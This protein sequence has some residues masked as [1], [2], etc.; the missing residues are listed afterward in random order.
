[1]TN[2]ELIAKVD[3]A[4]LASVE[5]L[6]AGGYLNPMQTNKFLHGII[7]QPTIIKNCRTVTII[8]EQKKIEK[9]GFG[10]RIMRPGVEHTALPESQYAKPQYGKVELWTKETIAETRI[11]YDTLEANIEKGNLRN[12]IIS[13]LQERIALDLEELVVRGDRDSADPY[14][15]ILDGILKKCNKWIIDVTGEEAPRLGQWTR[16]IR[17]IPAKYL[18]DPNAWRIYTNRLVDLA[19]KNHIASR[20]TVAGDRFLL[21]N[22]NSMALGY[23]I[24]PITMMPGG[25]QAGQYPPWHVPADPHPHPSIGRTGAQEELYPTGGTGD[26]SDGLAQ[27]LMTHPKNIIVGFTRRVQMEFDKDIS[28]RQIIIVTT[29]K[30]DTAIEEVDATA[31]M[32]GLNPTFPEEVDPAIS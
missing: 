13:L 7:D 2:N 1:M 21:Q 27:A 10:E 3:S 17:A 20:N 31:K 30:V 8:G 5:D 19:W 24:Q 25:L 6:S 22:T 14:L 18:R 4:V 12:T 9:I 29:L 16:L 11:S 26:D 28:R 32:I 23:E 15:A